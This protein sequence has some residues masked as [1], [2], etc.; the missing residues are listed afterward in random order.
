MAKASTIRALNRAGED[1]DSWTLGFGLALAEVNRRR[2][3]PSLIAEVA[4]DAGFDSMDQF[5]SAGL[6]EFDLKELRK[7]IPRRRQKRAR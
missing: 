7:C 3:C 4:R 1:D 2:D 5:E 6:D